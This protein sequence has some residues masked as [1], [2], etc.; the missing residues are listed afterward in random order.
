VKRAAEF[1]VA[2]FAG[3]AVSAMAQPRPGS[4]QMIRA[5]AP[6]TAV[7]LSAISNRAVIVSRDKKL[8]LWDL[9]GSRLL[10]TVALTT[11]DID[12]AAISDDGRWI[13]TGDHSGNMCVWDASTG[14]AQLQVRMNHY[15]GPVSFSRDNKFIAIAPMGD[16]VQVFDVA[17]SKLLYETKAVT[18]GTVALAFSRD[19]GSIAT[20]DADTAV[21]VY[22]AHT[23][24]LVAENRDFLLEPLAVDFTADGRQVVA[25]GGD[26]IL[27][28]IDGAS[29]KV[30]RRLQKIEEPIGFSSLKV[31]PD[32]SLVAGILMKANNMT[33]PA[34]VVMWEVSSGK[35]KSQWLPD[36]LALWMDWTRD[37]RLISVGFDSDSMVVWRVP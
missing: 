14:R 12:V 24:K 36:K 37:G 20:A 7:A 21:R 27:M 32:G 13:F 10:G 25:G 17:A 3:F 33:Q 5:Q 30:I 19:G 8:T 35:R 23:G 1:A 28:F 6:V 15:P 29:G 11:A 34:P 2:L 31:S 18:G 4:P 26:K 9:E 22:D 16:P